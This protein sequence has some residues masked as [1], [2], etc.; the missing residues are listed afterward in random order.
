MQHLL[1]GRKAAVVHVGRGKRDVPQ[2]WN[3]EPPAMRRVA[4]DRLEAGLKVL[5]V[6]EAV[7]GKTVQARAEPAGQELAVTVD[8]IAAAQAD[9]DVRVGHEQLAPQFLLRVRA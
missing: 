4:G 9:L 1:E 3:L 2:G 6:V 5:F 7:V 8:A